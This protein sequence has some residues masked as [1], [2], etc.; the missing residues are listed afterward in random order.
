[1]SRSIRRTRYARR[2]AT[3]CALVTTLA[4]PR[5]MHAADGDLD[6]TFRGTGKLTYATAASSVG[7]AALDASGRLL[8][9][10]TKQLSGTDRDL[11]YVRIPDAGAILACSVAID[12]G[13]TDTDEIYDLIGFGGAPPQTGQTIY[14]AGVAAGPSGKPARQAVVAAVN[15]ETCAPDSSFDGDGRYVITSIGNELL[16][17]AILAVPEDLG[18]LRVLFEYPGSGNFDVWP[19]DRSGNFDNN[20]QVHLVDLATRYGAT[21]FT[22]AGLARQSGGKII[23][24]GTMTLPGGDRDVVVVRFLVN[25]VIDVGFGSSGMTA[26]SYDIIDAGAD[27]ANALTLLPGDRIAIGGSVTRAGGSTQAAVAVLTADGQFDNGF[28]LVGRTS[29]DFV[30][31]GRRDV[32]R[33]VANQG[34]NLVAVGSTGANTLLPNYDFAVA[35]LLASGSAPLDTTFS[36]DG[37]LTVAFDLGGSGNN[38]DV[39]TSVV[40]DF[41]QR[42]FVGGYVLD[43][44]GNL[45]PAALRLQAPPP[46]LSTDGFES[47][48]LFGWDNH[49]G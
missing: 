49:V 11:A 15:N 36:A 8:L 43:G 25:G 27:V 5:P 29:F 30:G 2:L 26:F 7:K 46:P 45:L 1:M 17:R 16:S 12:L 32:I 42:I 18:T 14:L 4:V 38:V 22:G 31:P 34:N 24:A 41:A 9:P 19:L 37:R 40:I 48:A 35:R 28:G 10:Y 44:A 33:G 13:G 23:A 3:A 20:W 39:A 47:G 21:A 6:L